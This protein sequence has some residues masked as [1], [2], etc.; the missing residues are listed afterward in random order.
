MLKHGRFLAGVG[1]S[2]FFVFPAPAHSSAAGTN[3][4][5]ACHSKLPSGSFAGAK[6]HG[7]KGSAHQKA[8]VTCDK[9]HGGN[10]KAA[11]KEEAHKGVLGSED[12]ESMVYY[13]NVPSTCGQCHGAEAFKFNRSGHYKKLE[14]SGSGPTC[15]TCH[16]SMIV[17]VLTPDSVADV[18]G[19][20][21]NSQG[22]LP[23]VPQY[24][25]SVLLALRESQTMVNEAE[26]YYHPA[27]GTRAASDIT[28]ARV[29][30]HSAKL[31]WHTFDLESITEYLQKTYG[32]LKKLPRPRR[33]NK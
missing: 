18:C 23:Y 27:K 14:T 12:P 6:A 10:P 8:G 13:K 21:H 24:A 7:W 29:A 30:L 5:T 11:A 28:D 31:D 16:G 32:S 20:C 33:K 2:V 1:I 17:S 22:V 3:S 4:C 19:R 26:W 25:K 15:V 9:C